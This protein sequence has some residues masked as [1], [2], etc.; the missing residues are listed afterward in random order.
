MN[1]AKKL[2]E[3]VHELPL[4]VRRELCNI[5]VPGYMFAFMEKTTKHDGVMNRRLHYS[6]V[7][8]DLPDG[9][10]EGSAESFVHDEND[11]MIAVM[12]H[13]WLPISPVEIVKH[14]AKISGRQKTHV[15]GVNVMPVFD[16]CISQASLTIPGSHFKDKPDV[17]ELLQFDDDETDPTGHKVAIKLLQRVLDENA[18]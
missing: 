15:A 4:N 5:D 11:S 7:L 6:T 3:W 8:A 12:T 14:A 13:T 16:F 17:V 18:G 10:S 9:V 2:T 1:S